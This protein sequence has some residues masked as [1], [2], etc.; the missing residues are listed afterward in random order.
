MSNK[1]VKVDHV[2]LTL[3]MSASGTGMEREQINELVN[4]RLAEGYDTV[5]VY[6]ARTNFDDRIAPVDQIFVYIFKAFEKESA[7]AKKADA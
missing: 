4:R 1:V 2:V 5:D 3:K 7:K 6:L